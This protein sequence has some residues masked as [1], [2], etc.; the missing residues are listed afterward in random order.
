MARVRSPEKWQQLF[1]EYEASDER[2]R[3]ASHARA[4]TP[5]VIVK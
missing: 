1:A 3:L 5:L 4:P 2:A